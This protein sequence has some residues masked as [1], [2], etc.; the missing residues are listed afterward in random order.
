MANE[1]ITENLVRD[2]FRALKYGTSE[3]E[4][5]IEEQKSQIE[6]VTK[7]LKNASKQGGSG[8]G[9][10]EFIISSPAYPDFLIVVECKAQTNQHESPNRDKVAGYAVDGAIHYARFLAK[11]FNVIA[12]AASGQTESGLKI[13]TFLYPKGAATYKDFTNESGVPV[14][15]ILPFEDFVRLGSFDP[16]VQK[17][18][19]DDLMEFSKE[20]HDFMR[21]HAK[22]TESEKPLLVSGTLIALRNTAFAKVFDEY[23][24]SELQ[25]QW[26]HVI[27]EE[28]EKAEIPNSKKANMAQPYSSIAVHPE[29]G[30]SATK[31]P[32]GV[33]YELIKMLNEK[34]CPFVSIY[35]DFDVVGQFYGEFLKYTGGDK[36]ALGIV[37]TPRHVTELFALIANVNKNSKI[38]DICTGTGGF[39]VSAMQHMMRQTHTDS[40]RDNI[41]KNCLIGVEQQPSMYALAAS[42]MILR[43][44]GKANLYQGSCFDPAIEKAIKEHE[45]TV[46]MINP[47]YSQSDESLH[48]LMFIKQM[49]DCLKKG[50]TGVAIVPISCAISPHYLREEILNSHTLDAVMSMPQELFYPVGVVACI[51]VFKAGIKHSDSNQKTWFGYW[52]DDGFIKTKHKGRIDVNETWSTTRDHWIEQYRNREVHAGESVTQYVTATDEWCAEAYMETDYEKLNSEDF[53]INLKNYLAF[54][55]TRP[56]TNE[57]PSLKPNTSWKKF[58]LDSLFEL[59]KGKRLTK[60]D[61]TDG[62]IPYIGAIDSNNGISAYVGQD[63]IHTG[64]TITVS[65]NGSVAEAFYQPEDFWATDD[66]NVLYPKFEMTAEIGLFLCTLIRKEKY[67]FNYGRKWH[68]ERMKESIIRLPTVENGEP[69]WNFMKRYIK[70]LPFSSQLR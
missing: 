15:E 68:L 50:G 42:N 36:K 3:S 65:Y 56:T 69:D 48:E 58:S 54:K 29:L 13:S 47:P 10:P 67:R 21:D 38:L 28:I 5:I 64:Q 51:M 35:H 70:S 32:K 39:L 46:G 6:S 44:D 20:L 24:P 45:C 26:M 55:L 16:T 60:A 19:H 14:T 40:E 8:K 12:L 49:L 4:T 30:K 41:R 31:F 9:S 17:N 7:L 25:K 1:R 18:R 2:A 59:K 37:L 53:L 66:V 33:L 57:I 27:K 62:S 34:V 11:S 23:T 22:L 61:M 43:G 52:K 63:A